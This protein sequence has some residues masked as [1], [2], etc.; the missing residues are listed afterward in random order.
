MDEPNTDVIQGTLDMLILQDAEPRAD[1]RFGIARRVEQI[2]RGVFKVNPG[3]L[4]TALQR[5][6]RAGWLD[7]EW[8][9]T[10]NSRRAKFYSLTRSGQ[11]AARGRRRRTGRAARRR[12]PGCSRRRAERMSLWRQL[13][14]G[15]RVLTHRER[16]RSGARRRGASTT[17]SSPP[18][19]RIARG[20]VPDEARRAAM[21]EIGNMTVVARTGARRTAGRT[22]SAPARRSPIRARVGCASNPG[23]TARRVLTLALGIGASTAIFSAVN[24]ILFEPLPYPHASRIAMISDVHVDGEPLDVTFGTYLEL[25]RAQP[26]LRCDGRR[27]TPWQP[28][29]V[30]D[31]EPERLAG[32]RVGAGYFRTLGV[33]PF[34]GRDFQRRRRPSRRPARRDPERRALAAALRRRSHDRRADVE[35]RRQRLHRHRRDAARRSRMCWR[36]SAELWAPLQYNTVFG[37]QSREWGHHLR[38]VA[39]LLPGR[40]AWMPHAPSSNRIAQ[41]ARAGVRARPMGI[42]RQRAGRHVAAGRHDARHRPALMA[43]LGRVVLVLAIVCVNV[44]NLAARRAAPSGAASSPCAPRSAPADCGSFGKCSPRACARVRRRRARDGRGGARRARDGRAQ[45]RRAAARW[46]DPPGRR[47]CSPSDSSSRR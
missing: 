8:R 45:S 41:R 3:S 18:P 30:G 14:R 25:A 17:S 34:I 1:A 31:G 24:P 15:V 37:A 28:A 32:Q 22:S 33:A 42:A 2:S 13:T 7:A 23:F 39:R 9:Q 12:S 26:R 36:R 43:V 19:T 10:E 20:L 5:L 35:A 44:T 6:E 4:L 16:R 29:M 46:R 40:R 47:R 11:E 27:S 21:L 38:M